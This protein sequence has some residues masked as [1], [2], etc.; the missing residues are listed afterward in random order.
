MVLKAGLELDEAVKVAQM[1]V[2][3]GADALDVSAGGDEAKHWT[4]PTYM[5]ESGGLVYL[6]EA[7][8]QAVNVPVITVGKLG[9]PVLAE[10]VLQEGKADFIALGRPLLADPYLPL[11]VKEGR[12]QDICQC[13]YCGNCQAHSREKVKLIDY[14]AF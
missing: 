7:I 4:F 10:R 8:K 6:A 1:Y 5:Q 11:K 12:L 9:D 13:I 3:A 14:A 2:E